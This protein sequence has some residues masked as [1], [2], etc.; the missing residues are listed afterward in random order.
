MNYEYEYVEK[1][2]IESLKKL[3]WDTILF[4][5]GDERSKYYPELTLRKDFDQVILEDRF[6]A[7]IKKLNDWLDDE[8]IEQIYQDMKRIGQRQGLIETNEQF[9]NLL[10]EPPAFI[11]KKKPKEKSQ[12]IKLID[13][14]NPSENDFL[15]INQFRVNAPGTLRK[16]IVP[17]L[18]IFV[19]GFPLGVVEC[20]YPDKVDS[21]AMEDGIDQL[22]R[23]SNT[24]EEAGE[25]EGNKELFYYNQILISTTK[26]E[27]RMGTITSRYEDFLEWKDTH[28][29]PLDKKLHS[30]EKMIL[31]SL[32]KN[33][34][35]DLIRNFIIFTE[36]DNGAKIKLVARYQQYRAVNKVTEGI[37]NNKTPEERSGIVWHTQGSGK[38]LSMVFLIRKLRTIRDLMKYKVVMVTDR[39]DLQKQLSGTAGLAEKVY[40]MSNTAKLIK[41]L[42]TDTSNLV[43][44]TIQ[45]FLKRSKT[46]KNIEALPEF[47]VFPLLN[48]SE[49]ILLLVD[50]AHRTQSGTFG[51]NLV[52]SLPKSSRVAFTGTPIIT[53]KS[54]KAKKS[55]YDLFG[56]R[57]IDKYGMKES[58]DDGATLQIKYIGKTVNSKIKDKEELDKDFE[59]MFEDKTNEEKILIKK[60]YGT[61][62][63]I[64]EADKRIEKIS[65]DIVKHYFE[66]IF[67]N[68]FKAQIVASS[69]VAAAK[70]KKFIDKAVEEYVTEYSKRKD[71]DN[72]R[73]VLMKFIK[74]ACLVHLLNNDLPEILRYS[75]DAKRILGE[76]NINFKKPYD[77]NKTNTGITFLIVK[78]MLLTGFNAKIEQV[79]Y[80]DKK[81]TDH[82]LLQAI[83]RV[84]RIS[85]GKEYGYVVDYYGI[86][87]HLR[88]ALKA[89][90]SEDLD[91]NDVMTDVDTELPI[92]KNRYNELNK[93]FM[94]KGVKKIEEYV[95]YQIKNTNEQLEILEKCLDVLEEVKIRAK[96][97]VKFKLFIDS[98]DVLFTKP[99]C[100]PYLPVMRAYG[101]I[102]N[103]AQ[104]RFRDDTINL[105]GAGKRV[106]KLIN[107]HLI[108][109]G[110][111]TKIKPIDIISDNFD[112]EL[113][114]NKSPKS[115]ASEME[116]AIRKHCKVNFD[117]DPTYYKNISEKLE[118]IILGF[119]N[120]W[121][122]Q[123]IYLN[124]LKKQMREGRQKEEEGLDPK[125]HAPFYDLIIQETYENKE[126]TNKE[127]IK[128][129]VIK[130]FNLI[131]EEI[132][133]VG[134][135]TNPQKIKHLR[136][137]IDDQLITIG[138]KNIYDKK[139]KIVSE[140]M[141]LAK[142]RRRI[143]ENER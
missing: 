84:N 85:K 59:D 140:I 50:E 143:F 92:L 81:M 72:E 54:K 130:L 106:K 1:P 95:N 101:H 119:K 107:E 99:V 53:E 87:N 2:F 32:S 40:T 36:N 21:N 131:S 97:N 121:E 127:N 25:A 73:L 100:R 71:C 126:V 3:G 118:E 27:A 46:K 75:K 22:K 39:K 124:E 31:G 74:S 65:K 96:F 104:H 49:N 138:N 136:G 7:A 48:D 139:E 18:V 58:R 14:D 129:G 90:S 133:K 142:N 34:F 141:K 94:D 117:T 114:K 103:R 12:S 11:D 83:A 134:F 111:K 43:M 42:K 93:L 69:R 66:N 63:D 23:Y 52:L 86:T 78:D 38:S 56:N 51:G 137:M 64:L 26:D 113:D 82:T 61:K 13:F 20:K 76:D 35:I 17:D 105:L 57:Y 112:E 122:E 44:V 28:P 62:G 123:L 37:L 4:E 88:N 30:Q 33:N 29:I 109:I 68:G 128:E 8:Q 70:Y 125:K 15:A 80:L 19:N 102:H 67:D 10:L 89:Y 47:E 5:A 108:S 98:L 115:K 116:H 60:K 16:F 91:L 79:M 135:W 110:I 120:N 45:K 41:E 24:R 132:I 77:L 9:T 6:K 55:T